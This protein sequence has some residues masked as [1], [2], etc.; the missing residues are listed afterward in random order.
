MAGFA[1]WELPGRWIVYAV[2][3]ESVALVLALASFT[4]G[5]LTDVALLRFGIL[6]ALGMVQAELSRRI[7]RDRRRM[8]GSTHINMTSIWLIPAVLMLP[9]QLVA[10][11]C[12]ALYTHMWLR[13]W[14]NLR[15]VSLHRT[16]F[17]ASAAI[18]ACLAANTVS[19]MPLADRLPEW[20]WGVT[21]A[22][23]LG[24]L[25]FEL[26]DALLL[27]VSINLRS[28]GNATLT[29][30]FGSWDDNALELTT[31]CLGGLTALT[32]VYQPLFTVLLF[33]PIVVLHR[34]VLVKE[35]E[36]AATIDVKTGLLNAVTW[37]HMATQELARTK[38]DRRATVGVLM[39]DLDHFKRVNDTYGHLAGDAVLKSVA[40]AVKGQV[41]ADDAVGRF[42]GEEFVV[43]L[44]G[45]D[46]AGALV[47]AE[48]IRKTVGALYVMSPQDGVPIA[49]LTCS[50]G[51]AVH[52]SSGTTMERLLLA[53]DTAVY[54]AK[55]TGRN[56]VVSTMDKRDAA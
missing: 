30:L 9:P 26:V 20:S 36:A 48:R 46:D 54:R 25:T 47:V 27:A 16:V 37:H 4:H 28:L 3:L 38:Q 24:G 15:N 52:R 50:I 32:L 11:L 41:R 7:E 29:E 13:I 19:N 8:S 34:S 1:L 31:L 21:M 45:V 17:G 40:A 23:L 18:L 2:L 51:V 43:L 44:P 6:L 22:C 53:A 55:R 5:A 35:L 14:Q 39:V 42:G 10:V 12:V 33:C 56:R 49:G